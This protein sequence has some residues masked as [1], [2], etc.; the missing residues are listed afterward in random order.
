MS[1]S[2][3][4]LSV[5]FAI[6]SFCTLLSRYVGFMH[7]LLAFFVITSLR[8]ITSKRDISALFAIC[9]FY[10][11]SVSSVCDI[12][13]L[14]RFA[15]SYFSQSF[16]CD[17]TFT[18]IYFSRPEFRLVRWYINYYVI[19]NSTCDPQIAALS[20]WVYRMSDIVLS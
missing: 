5:F 4:D 11:L 12:L 19:I 14:V 16:P 9:R 1:S 15:I 6:W 18:F 10:S 2:V 7:I 17:V 8:V 13:V 3:H 20:G